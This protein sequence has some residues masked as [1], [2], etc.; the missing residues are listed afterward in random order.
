MSVTDSM[1]FFFKQFKYQLTV[2]VQH[3][4]FGPSSLV[5]YKFVFALVQHSSVLHASEDL[6]MMSL[7][8]KKNFKKNL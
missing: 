5:H 6:V 8:F 2:F 4:L 3:P 7:K 1:Y